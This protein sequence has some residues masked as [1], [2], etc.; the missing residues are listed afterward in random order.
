MADSVE[1]ISKLYNYKALKPYT[2]LEGSIP[3]KHKD[4]I[5]GVEIEL[6]Q[7]NVKYKLGTSNAIEDGSLKI[8]GMEF[9]TVPLKLR[10]LEV[11]LTRIFSGLDAPLVSS[12][13]SIHVHMNVRDMTPDQIINMV[14][15]Y[16]IF[17]RGLYRISGDRWN[18]NFCVPIGLAPQLLK[19]IFSSWDNV[20]SWSWYKYTGL[21]LCPIWGGE[22]SHKLGTVEFR[23]MRGSTDV[24]EIIGW[25]NMLAALKRAAQKM[26]QGELIA[27][28]R[29]MNTTS[30]Y[31]WLVREVFGKWA[32]LLSYQPTFAEDVE[33]AIS[34]LKI[35][36]PESVLM[37]KEKVTLKSLKTPSFCDEITQTKLKPKYKIV[38]LDIAPSLEWVT[39]PI[40]EAPVT[41]TM[42]GSF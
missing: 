22:G 14:L 28:I 25:C 32:K 40:P 29:T 30:G 5:F 9:V 20:S 31:Y 35:Y 27:H 24:K 41:P 2:G 34:I 26:D 6:E 19:K 11:E 18:S 21:N 7:V 38:N 33:T 37:K 15:L 8:N 4:V 36:L 16:T 42:E 39:S 3:I 23:Q 13:C 12:R 1:T 10:Y 17:E